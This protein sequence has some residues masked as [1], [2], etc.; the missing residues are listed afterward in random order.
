[1]N[2]K[3]LTV[4]KP[5]NKSEIFNT[6]NM[7]E[8]SRVE[9]NI[10]TK[11]DNRIISNSHV[12]PIYEL[13]DFSPFAKEILNEIENYFTPETY[14]LKI[15]KGKQELRLIGE[16]VIIN[17]DKYNKMFNILNSTDR[18]R[19][20]QVNIGL[21]RL[22]CTNGMVVGV[23]NEYSTARTKH[24][25]KGLPEKVELFMKSL[26]NFDL[27]IN[28]QVESLESLRGKFVSFKELAN[29]LIK[30]DND[31]ISANKMLK[32]RAF[33][34]KLLNSNTDALR[35]LNYEQKSLIK[36]AQNFNSDQYANIDVDINA[37]DALNCYTEV[38]RSFDSSVIK[39]ETNRIL[40]LI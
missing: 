15:T 30:N 21:M 11:F 33:S 8:I 38:F 24:Y 25:V 19:A 5:F 35:N 6:L 34:N 31:I 28:Y 16:D 12:S 20:L 2:R 23:E 18:T 37:Y 17:G 39:R 3:S 26:M 36:N 22:V 10:I 14:N 4:Q 9:N 29:K 27:N 32:F 40:E 1:M 13:F 7:L